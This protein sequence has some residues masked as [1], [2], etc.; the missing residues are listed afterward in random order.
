V[1][2]SG[3]VAMIV[4]IGKIGSLLQFDQNRK[5]FIVVSTIQSQSGRKTF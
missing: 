1:T 5:R 3:I 4:A 2:L